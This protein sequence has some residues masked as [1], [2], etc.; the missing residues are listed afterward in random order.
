VSDPASRLISLFSG[1]T[2]KAITT[3]LH[4]LGAKRRK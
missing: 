4:E 3:R 1:V 2:P